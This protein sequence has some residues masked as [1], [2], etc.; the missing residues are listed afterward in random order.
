MPM[1]AADN[2]AGRHGAAGKEVERQEEKDWSDS[3]WN[4]TEV[5]PFLASSLQTPG[6]MI[7]K[8]LSVKVGSGG[9]A[10]V[11]YDLGK[12]AMRAAW[13]GGFLK[14][15]SV[16]FG[17]MGAPMRAGEWAFST[18]GPAGWP[19]AGGRHEALRVQGNRVV[20]ETRVGGTLVRETPWF[21]RAGDLNVF[22]RTFVIEPGIYI[23]QSALDALPRTAENLA[24][25]QNIQ[26]AVTKYADIGVR[27]E[28]AFLLEA[29]GLRR[30]TASVPRTI[31][32]VEAFLK[33][34]AA[35]R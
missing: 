12:P 18:A 20:L 33:R 1:S 25:I 19:W 5:G 34:P 27:I 2:D 26:P 30:L 6:G 3:R 14:F 31:E 13:T 29:S 11:C 15:Q 35:S 4:Q 10:S 17:I 24:L 23:R 9:E 21:D 22:S 28:D 7:V 16:R 8:A 32:E